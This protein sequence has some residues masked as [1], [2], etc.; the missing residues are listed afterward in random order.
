MSKAWVVSSPKFTY[1][2]MSGVFPFQIP[3][4]VLL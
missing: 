4:L 3:S 2:V 1:G